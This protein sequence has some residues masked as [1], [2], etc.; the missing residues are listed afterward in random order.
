VGVEEGA[1]RAQWDDDPGQPHEPLPS[2]GDGDGDDPGHD[3]VQQDAPTEARYGAG[4]AISAEVEVEV[5]Q[6]G[7]Q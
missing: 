3:R 4:T 1:Q 5:D 2:G 7:D 6:S